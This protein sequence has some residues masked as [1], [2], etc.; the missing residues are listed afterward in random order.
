MI[1]RCI[2][3]TPWRATVALVALALAACGGGSKPD[4]YAAATSVQER[5]CEN[6]DGTA[7]D[8]CLA[9][10]VRVDD[11]AVATTDVNRATYAC[12][13][14]NFVCDEASGLATA[15]SRQ[16]QYDCMQDLSQ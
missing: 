15:E 9:Q 3:A 14:D 5:C 11:P 13:R 8:E 10:V 7:R 12:V 6:I 4:T 1:E 16:A 2:P